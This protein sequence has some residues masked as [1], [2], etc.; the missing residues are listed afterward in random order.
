MILERSLDRRNFRRRIMAM[1]CSKQRRERRGAHRPA[2]LYSFQQQQPADHRNAINWY[3]VIGEAMNKSRKKG[4]L[5]AS[6]AV[7][8]A[9][10]RLCRGQRAPRPPRPAQQSRPARDQQYRDARPGAVHR[11]RCTRPIIAAREHP[12]LL[13][14]LHCY[15]GCDRTDG[16]KNLLDCFRDN[17]GGHCAICTGEALEAE[18]L[19]RQGCRSSKSATRCA[20]ATPTE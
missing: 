11:A 13:A 18:K 17:H 1:D 9:G 5:I 8:R 10:G 6:G 14:Q 7:A 2:A 19:A 4:V 12:A 3:T 15:C 16:H 20:S